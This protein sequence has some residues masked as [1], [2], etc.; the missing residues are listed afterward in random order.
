MRG[1]LEQ[2]NDGKEMSFWAHRLAV[3]FTGVRWA[4]ARSTSL[5]TRRVVDRLFG[6]KNLARMRTRQT[7]HSSL[8]YA[9]ETGSHCEGAQLLSW[10]W[11][12]DV[13]VDS[14]CPPSA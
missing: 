14:F 7:S 8:A 6:G 2:Q 1:V 9:W 12:K 10:I 4:P 13:Q 5:T 11:R 3:R